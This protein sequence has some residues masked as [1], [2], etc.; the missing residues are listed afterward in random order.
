MANYEGTPHTEGNST[1]QLSLVKV[2]NAFGLIKPETPDGLLPTD[3]SV[4]EIKKKIT[5]P[6]IVRAMGASEQTVNIV[7]R[8]EF[9]AN[10]LDSFSET[11]QRYFLDQA[12][13]VFQGAM[14]LLPRDGRKLVLNLSRGASLS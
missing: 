11:G 14:I 5:N 8:T 12:D 13:E 7:Y 2:F 3:T 1:P 6:A 9:A 10:L 4:E